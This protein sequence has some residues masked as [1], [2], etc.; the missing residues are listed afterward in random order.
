MGHRKQLTSYKGQ[1][2]FWLDNFISGS[3]STYM[4]RWFCNLE[5]GHR[6]AQQ[7][8]KN[9][10]NKCLRARGTPLRPKDKRRSKSGSHP[11]EPRALLH[12]VYMDY[13]SM[14]VCMHGWMDGWMDG[15]FIWM[16][17]WMDAYQLTSNRIRSCVP[18]VPP[19]WTTTF[20]SSVNKFSK[21]L[22]CF[23]PS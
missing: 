23:P 7:K 13:A 19:A 21:I 2:L 11:R 5:I 14:Q 3:R 20:W 16:D 22:S 18:Q 8:C 15:W 6:L 10:K 12:K 17:G 1:T 4:K 9:I